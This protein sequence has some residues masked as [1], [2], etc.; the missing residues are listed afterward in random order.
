VE[1]WLLGRKTH[2]TPLFP[3]T[4][5]PN[6]SYPT[7]STVRHLGETPMFSVWFIQWVGSAA[8]AM[9][10]LC[11]AQVQC[12]ANGPA[13]RW[14]SRKSNVTARTYWPL[15]DKCAAFARRFNWFHKT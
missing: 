13:E 15:G 9:G 7:A 1:S 6:N 11:E 4:P 14:R 8:T 3:I 10:K 2:L 5:T 12:R